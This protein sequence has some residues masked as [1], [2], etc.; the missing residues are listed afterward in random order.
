MILPQM[1]P[2]RVNG[3]ESTYAIARQ[4]QQMD[5]IAFQQAIKYSLA[6]PLSTCQTRLRLVQILAQLDASE[7]LNIVA[8]N[9]ILSMSMDRVAEQ[10]SRQ[11]FLVDSD[12]MQIITGEYNMAVLRADQ[13]SGGNYSKMNKFSY[14]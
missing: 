3:E 11:G 5:I 8:Y 4:F 2:A 14:W 1:A 7:L 6:T 9:H 10:Q 12:L 13:N